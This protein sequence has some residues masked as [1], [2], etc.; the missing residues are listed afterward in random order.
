MNHNSYL[1]FDCECANCF[2][3]EGKICSLGYVLTDDDFNIIEKDDVLINPKCEFDWYILN[4]KNPC[5]LAYSKDEFR[6]QPDFAAYY[7]D[8][9]KLFTSG[10]RKIF[11][12]AVDGDVGFVNTA[13]ER[14]NVPYIQFCAFDV[15]K[16]LNQSYNNKMK[17]KEWCDFLKI[18]T[19]AF[20]AHRSVDDAEM[21]MLCFK[22]VCEK[23]GL[24]GDEL[25][26][27]FHDFTVTTDRMIEVVEERKYKK[28]LKDKLE[29][30][31]NK[32]NPFPKK[33]I[34]KKKMFEL[35]KAIYKDLEEALEVSKKI[36][37]FGGVITRHV[38][39]NGYYIYSDSISEVVKLKYESRGN[40][41]LSLTELETELE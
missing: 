24:S 11:G 38:S 3:G 17:L 39:S 10:N 5:H 23:L 35:D 4:P 6:A 27:K 8:I 15:Q 29:K 13:C 16:I 30:F 21:T 26:E 31:V 19:A 18:D 41:V 9:K 34:F 33:D 12:F 20:K 1:F 22:K 40:K 2:D 37:D 28:E 25:Y 32:K 36:Y 14:A 7:K